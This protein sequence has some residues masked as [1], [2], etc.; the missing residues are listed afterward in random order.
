MLGQ[1]RDGGWIMEE[2]RLWTTAFPA[3][4]RG[5]L[6]KQEWREKSS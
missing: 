5:L 3:P 2:R 1:G 4:S 6:G